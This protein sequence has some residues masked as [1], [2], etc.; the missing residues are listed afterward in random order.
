[1]AQD[2]DARETTINYAG[3]SLTM[4]VGNLKSLY[5]EDTNVF[6]ADG[7]PMTVSVK[8]HTRVRVIGGS[9]T[10]VAPTTREYIQWPTNDRS[11]AAGGTPIMMSW[12]GSEGEWGA[13]VSGPLWKLGSFLQTTSLKSVWFYA[14]GGKGYGPF[15][16]I[17]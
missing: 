10:T 14:K 1:M 11:N 16:K 12:T 17:S 13:R 15:Q 4:T 3:G 9:T 6:G 5:G 8:G 2:L 7:K